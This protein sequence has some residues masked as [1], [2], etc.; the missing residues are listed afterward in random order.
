[1]YVYIYKLVLAH[2][3][4]GLYKDLYIVR[5]IKVA[6]LKWLGHLLRMGENSP[7]KK[8]T[9]SHPESSRKKVPKLRWL[10]CVLKDVQFL[11]IETWWKKARD[12]SIWGRI[13]MEAKVH[14]EL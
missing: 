7:C 8:V 14:K 11:K 3:L 10:H 5:V 6:T 12:K 9:F 2:E 13:I 1:V 4:Y